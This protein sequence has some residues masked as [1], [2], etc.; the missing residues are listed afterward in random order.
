MSPA[1]TPQPEERRSGI[2]VQLLILVV[3][4]TLGV[5]G[6]LGKVLGMY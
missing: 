3:I 2:P 6:L 1:A 5:L 4:M